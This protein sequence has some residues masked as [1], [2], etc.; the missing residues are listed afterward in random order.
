LWHHDE[1]GDHEGI[2]FI[3]TASV[4]HRPSVSSKA[5][6]KKLPDRVTGTKG[7]E[8]QHMRLI[9]FGFGEF[10]IPCLISL[11]HNREHEIGGVVAVNGTEQLASHDKRPSNPVCRVAE[12]FGLSCI[13]LSDV[14]SAKSLARLKPFAADLGI[15]VAAFGLRLP[16][17][18]REPF[19]SGCIG[20]YPTLLPQAILKRK[21][22]S[23][24]SVMISFALRLL[25]YNP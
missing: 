22:K 16:G 20:I 10:A 18:L 12:E 13:N 7:L 25:F 15:V 1:S 6:E 8:D 5:D 9:F 19:T 2:G 4:L 11:I 23:G 17:S 14:G 24:I 21:T 3:N